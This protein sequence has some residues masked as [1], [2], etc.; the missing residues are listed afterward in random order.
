MN[1]DRGYLPE[2]ILLIVIGV[3]MLMN[4]HAYEIDPFSELFHIEAAKEA[5]GAGRFAIPLI[6]GHDYLIR[7]PFWTWVV[8]AFFKIFKV[9]LFAARLPA[10][11]CALGGLIL[12]WMLAGALT[13]NRTAALL[14]TAML[15]TTWGWFYGASLSTADVLATDIYLAFGWMLTRWQ[16]PVTRRNPVPK[17]LNIFSAIFGALLG[18][19][20]LVKG[21]LSA[22]LLGLIGLAYIILETN[23]YAYRRINWLFFL[24]P[25]VLIPLPW[26]VW[27]SAKTGYWGFSIDYLFMQPVA[28]FLAQGPWTGLKV[29]PLFYLR[30]LPAG[31]L[32]YLPILIAFAI[33]TFKARRGTLRNE[34]WLL[35]LAVWSGLLLLVYSFSAFQEPTLLLPVYPPL[36]ILGAYYVSRVIELPDAT[37]VY[38]NMMAVTVVGLMLVAVLS[39]LMVFQVLPNDYVL[40]FWHMPG[41]PVL[42]ALKLGKH[43]IDLPE[44]FPFWKLWL[45]PGPFI[46]L[47]GGVV[48]YVMQIS[49]RTPQT[50]IALIATSLLFL[51]FIK[52]LYLP[53]LQRPVPQAFAQR[54]NKQTQA[55]DR[56]VLYS[57]HPDV[58]RVMF[59]LAD[60]QLARTRFVRN[61]AGMQQS[62]AGTAGGNSTVYGV[63]REKSFFNDLEFELRSLLRVNQFNWKWDTN[64]LGELRKFLV[65]R[66]PLFDKMKSDMIFFQSVPA[67]ASSIPLD[68]EF[69]QDIPLGTG[70]EEPGAPGFERIKRNRG[71]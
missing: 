64:R 40:G 18:F 24:L 66:Q 41:Q 57:L 68:Q 47:A 16:G 22:L 33:D 35:W 4:V 17:E 6:H 7:A 10:V 11:L 52:G 27:V 19:L 34:P 55:N 15:A 45:I 12:T 26:L 42:A 1:N 63:I 13:Q 25:L 59:Y 32:P 38:N 8:I 44:A 53:M 60:D 69:A 51:L 36:M 5:L 21:P 2:I 28:R 30:R 23:Q 31:L 62:L 70:L 65:V 14:A 20:L 54:L 3:L 71:H 9:G 37:P 67:A 58:K 49:R 61:P 29:N 50:V 46:L 43:V 48:L 56:I 39:T